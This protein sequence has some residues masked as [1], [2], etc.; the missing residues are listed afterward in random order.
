MTG[1]AVLVG[2]G[3]GRDLHDPGP[4]RDGLSKPYWD[5]LKAGR[6]LIQRCCGCGVWQWGPEWI[7]HSCHGFDLDRLNFP[8]IATISE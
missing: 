5:G 1:P 3:P 2:D 6:L 7:C 4:E 8:Q